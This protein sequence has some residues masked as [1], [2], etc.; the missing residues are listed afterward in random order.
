MNM[1]NFNRAAESCFLPVVRFVDRITWVVL[2]IMML[3]TMTDVFLRKFSNLSILGTVELT[4]LMMIIIVFCSLAQCQANDGHIKVD[5]VLKR[6]SPRLQSIF[7]V[8][9]QFICFALFSTMTYAIWRHANSMKEWGEITV[10]LALPV[11]PFIY[12]AVVGC[13]L[14]ALVLLIKTLAALSEVIQS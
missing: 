1:R 5:L 6:L 12:I 3:M 2:F 13:A 14:L 9:T 7:D 8:I 11:Y 10:D 4:E